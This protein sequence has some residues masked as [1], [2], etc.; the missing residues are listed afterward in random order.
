M[1]LLG[2]FRAHE[3][4][5]TTTFAGALQI[6]KNV[7]VQVGCIAAA[8]LYCIAA[9]LACGWVAAAMQVGCAAD[10]CNR[11]DAGAL[12]LQ[13]VLNLARLVGG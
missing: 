9:G 13:G 12:M 7:A 6:T 2:V 8:G 1:D 10:Y 11:I 5:A 4:G 3:V